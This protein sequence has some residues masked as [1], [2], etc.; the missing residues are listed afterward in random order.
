MKV[1]Q[2]VAAGLIAAMPFT[3]TACADEDGDGATTDEEVNQVDEVIEDLA[4][5]LETEI[6]QGTEEVAE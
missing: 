4:S 1:R 2:A 6:E 5:T 3:L